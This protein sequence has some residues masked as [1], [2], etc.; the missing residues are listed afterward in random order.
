MKSSFEL[1]KSFAEAQGSSRHNAN[2][3]ECHGKNIRLDHFE[4]NAFEQQ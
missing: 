2:G 3:E 1:I 4:S